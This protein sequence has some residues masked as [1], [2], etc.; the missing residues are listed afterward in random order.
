MI[1]RMPKILT[2]QLHQQL[3]FLIGDITK[4]YLL[5]NVVFTPLLKKLNDISSVNTFDIVIFL[6]FLLKYQRNKWI[7]NFFF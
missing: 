4:Y 7:I 2:M 6:K 5:V 3:F 1:H